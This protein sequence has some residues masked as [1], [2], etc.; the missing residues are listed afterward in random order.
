[1]LSTLCQAPCAKYLILCALCYASG[2]KHLMPR[3]L[4][5]ST[6]HKVLYIRLTGTKYP[7]T[8]ALI[9]T[10]QLCGTYKVVYEVLYFTTIT[11]CLAFC[12]MHLVNGLVNLYSF[13]GIQ[14]FGLN[15]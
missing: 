8:P 3:R 10:D 2:A 13:V 1:M 11:L 5:Q 12:C 7:R 6:L 4:A 9:Y 15:A 14:I